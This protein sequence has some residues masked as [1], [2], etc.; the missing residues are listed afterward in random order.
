[1]KLLT[2]LAAALGLLGFAGAAQAD[3]MGA[4]KPVTDQT[5]ETPTVIL[6]ETVGS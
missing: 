4:H 6:P 2:T 3:C 1:M 5:A